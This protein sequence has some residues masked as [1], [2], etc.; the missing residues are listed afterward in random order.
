[1]SDD[2]WLGGVAIGVTPTGLAVSGYDREAEAIAIALSEGRRTNLNKLIAV[3]DTIP[4]TEFGPDPVDVTAAI[5]L[6]RTTAKADGVDSRTRARDAM[7]SL[8]EP[9]LTIYAV[10][11]VESGGKLAAELVL[12]H[13]RCPGYVL[14]RASRSRRPEIDGCRAAT[15]HA[16]TRP[17]TLAAIYNA[18]AGKHAR[19]DVLRHPSCPRDI[20]RRASLGIDVEERA[21]ALATIKWLDQLHSET[22]A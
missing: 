7:N 3:L 4:T 22:S 14:D 2:A 21:A 10:L 19:L 15:Q 20:L 6:A 11:I 5:S 8:S 1:M 18:K 13:E 9:H 17:D 16:N 12:G